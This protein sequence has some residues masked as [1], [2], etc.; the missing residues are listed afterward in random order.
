MRSVNECEL[1]LLPDARDVIA[2]IA[3]EETMEKYHKSHRRFY[4]RGPTDIVQPCP[5]LCDLLAPGTEG[6]WGGLVGVG[7]GTRTV[8]ALVLRD[9]GGEKFAPGSG[10]LRRGGPMQGEMSA[11]CRGVMAIGD[12]LCRGGPADTAG[13]TARRVR[14]GSDPLV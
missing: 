6:H 9:P 7:V 2:Y 4:R 3:G 10:V 5:A 12:A 8:G 14:P 11:R 13:A 1:D